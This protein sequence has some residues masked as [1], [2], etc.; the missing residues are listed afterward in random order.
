M[1]NDLTKVMEELLNIKNKIDE[2]IQETDKINKKLDEQIEAT[3]PMLSLY[4]DG[5]GTKRTV[6]FI[7]GILISIGIIYASFKGIGQS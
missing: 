2:Q 6:K 1:D 5:V 7:A 4:R 3:K